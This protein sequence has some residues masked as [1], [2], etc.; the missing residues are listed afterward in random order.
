MLEK[1]AIT[2]YATKVYRNCYNSLTFAMSFS[3]AA[4]LGNGLKNI[5]ENFQDYF[6]QGYVNHFKLAAFTGFLYVA[7]LARINKSKHA[8]I[9]AN[10]FQAGMASAFLALHY[11]QGTENPIETMIFPATIGFMIVNNSVSKSELE[12]VI[13]EE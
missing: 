7:T 2:E 9:Y 11:Y 3:S 4:G 8:R 10:L 6:G 13:G 12:K 5:G 1:A